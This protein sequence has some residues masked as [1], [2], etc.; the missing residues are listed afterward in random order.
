MDKN[1][2]TLTLDVSIKSMEDAINLMKKI[3][4]ESYV[5]EITYVTVNQGRRYRCYPTGG[6]RNYSSY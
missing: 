3:N 6:Y 5:N 2:V 4:N 1:F